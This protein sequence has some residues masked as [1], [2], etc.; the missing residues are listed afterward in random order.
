MAQETELLVRCC[1]PGDEHALSLVAQGTILETYAGITEGED[2][3]AYA[4]A[5]LTVA[6]FARML[7]SERMRTWICET[8]AGN[9][10]IGYAQAV[11]DEGARAFASFEL[12]RLYVFYRFHGQRLGRRLLDEVLSFARQQNSE[13]IW[14]QVH[15]E[16]SHAI[17]FYR[18]LG[19]V[20][21]G[22]VLYPAGKRSYHSLTF[23]LTP[24]RQP[25]C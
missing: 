19:F 24:P 25:P 5:E 4:N 3:I 23:A 10:P 21:T 22:A 7:A 15:E 12:K 6:E 16:N 2:L 17:E 18:R 8:R 1:K 9:C 11:S 14:L 13:K 20:E